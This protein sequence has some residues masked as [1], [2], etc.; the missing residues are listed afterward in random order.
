[1]CRSPHRNRSSHSG[2]CWKS[3]VKTP[4]R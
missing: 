3:D 4:A 1:M 2:C